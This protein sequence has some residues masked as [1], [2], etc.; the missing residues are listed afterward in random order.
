M[1]TSHAQ[2]RAQQRRIPPIVEQWL[3]EFGEESYDG[4]GAVRRYFSHASIKR[5][6]RALGAQFVEHNARWFRVYKADV[7]AADL[8]ITIGWR[9][10]PIRGR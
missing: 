8:T 4:H 7:V 2:I 9:E 3:D 5:M 1:R 10:E 6:K